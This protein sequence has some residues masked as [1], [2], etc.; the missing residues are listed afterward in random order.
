MVHL[1]GERAGHVLDRDGRA[2][3]PAR[4]GQRLAHHAVRAVVDDVRE[5]ARLSGAVE[6][7]RHGRGADQSL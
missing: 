7:H 4:T 1:H 5:A 6:R 3:R 2:G